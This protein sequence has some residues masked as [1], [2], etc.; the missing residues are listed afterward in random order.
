MKITIEGI[1]YEINMQKAKELGICTE[2]HKPIKDFNVGDVFERASDGSKLRIL[3]SQSVF[4]SKREGKYNIAGLYGLQ[5][6]SDFDDRYIS[7]KELLKWLN[8][9]N[10]KFVKNI[11]K[12]ISNLIED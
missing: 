9:R 10:Y 12:Q 5:L 1:N 11:N 7:R 6:F 3:I 8:E 2:I 4:A